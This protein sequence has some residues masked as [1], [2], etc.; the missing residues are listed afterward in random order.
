MN[1][2]V[3]A[4][5]CCKEFLGNRWNKKF[6]IGTVNRGGFAQGGTKLHKV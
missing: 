4:C 5:V 2:L 6:E 3:R 1:N